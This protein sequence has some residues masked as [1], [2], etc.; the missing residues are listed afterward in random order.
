MFVQIRERCCCVRCLIEY[1]SEK[2]LKTR[3]RRKYHESDILHRALN[4]VA[5]RILKQYRS[6]KYFSFRSVRT[7]SV[8]VRG[9]EI[10]VHGCTVSVEIFG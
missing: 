2:K 1:N 8:S 6:P 4:V 10:N 5:K 7:S 9:I 3:F